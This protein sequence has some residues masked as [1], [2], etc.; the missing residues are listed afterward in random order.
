MAGT[1]SLGSSGRNSDVG[2]SLTYRRIGSK[3]IVRTEEAAETS[4]R[5][6]KDFVERPIPTKLGDLASSSGEHPS[7]RELSL[8]GFLLHAPDTTG[9]VSTQESQNASRAQIHNGAYTDDDQTVDVFTQR[10]TT[11]FHIYKN[12]FIPN[13]LYQFTR[14]QLTY[15]SGQDQK[16]TY[17][18]FERFG[19]YYGGTLNEFRIRAN[20]R[21]AAKFSIAASET[22][23]R[24]ACPCPTAIFPSS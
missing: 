19:G 1:Q 22:W 18:F 21:P 3:K 4:T 23:D 20:Y 6:G 17:N 12:V 2:A 11:P 10:I 14:H 15:G 5:K 16:F 13:G 8:E 9:Q 24:F 7:I